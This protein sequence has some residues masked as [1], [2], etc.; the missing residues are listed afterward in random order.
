MCHA[1]LRSLENLLR[2]FNDIAGTEKMPLA[3]DSLEHIAYECW[4]VVEGTGYARITS[5]WCEGSRSG[6][7]FIG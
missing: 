6:S 3:G 5:W 2:K 7:P 1:M 4:K